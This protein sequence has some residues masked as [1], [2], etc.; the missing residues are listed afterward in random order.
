MRDEYILDQII[1]QQLVKVSNKV[2]MYPRLPRTF[3][4]IC[5]VSIKVRESPFTFPVWM[6]NYM[7]AP[8][9]KELL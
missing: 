8:V 5:V 7:V 4:F 3:Q 1:L 2:T 6:I 9:I